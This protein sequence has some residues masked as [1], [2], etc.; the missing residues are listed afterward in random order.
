M[1]AARTGAAAAAKT[2]TDQDPALITVR[3]DLL[4]SKTHCPATLLTIF[5]VQ[6]CTFQ[7]C[8]Y[9]AY[10]DTR[11]NRPAE[12]RIPTQSQNPAL[13][14]AFWLWVCHA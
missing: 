14:E 10:L 7:D 3:R 12:Y 13:W 8:S 1:D 5:A 9:R 6:L 2:G 4:I 11:P